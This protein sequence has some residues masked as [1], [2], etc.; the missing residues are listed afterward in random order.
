MGLLFSRRP[1]FLAPSCITIKSFNISFN[2]RYAQPLEIHLAASCALQAFVHFRIVTALFH[3]EDAI[4]RSA[5]R[6]T[7]TKL[8]TPI[9]SFSV[10]SEINPDQWSAASGRYVTLQIRPL[11]EGVG[12]Q[13][14][15]TCLARRVVHPRWV[16]IKEVQQY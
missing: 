12:E 15:Q 7:N 5:W 9:L 2:Q 13:T 3:H 11:Q 1:M 14:Q 4:I 6:A 10:L 8:P 16:S